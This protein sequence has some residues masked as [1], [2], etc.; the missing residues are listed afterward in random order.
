MVFA[1]VFFVFLL[2]LLGDDFRDGGRGSDS[3]FSWAFEDDTSVS[4]VRIVLESLEG[5]LLDQL[6]LL[7]LML[8]ELLRLLLEERLGLGYSLCLTNRKLSGNGRRHL[9]ITYLRE[10][11]WCGGKLETSLLLIRLLEQLRSLSGEKLLSTAQVEVSH[12]R[13]QMLRLTQIEAAQSGRSQLLR[14]AQIIATRALCCQLLGGAKIVTLQSSRPW[15]ALELVQLLR[16]SQTLGLGKFQ[17]LRLGQLQGTTLTLEGVLGV[18]GQQGGEIHV[19]EIGSEGV[20]LRE[21]GVKSA[22]QGVELFR[23]DADNNDWLLDVGVEWR[24]RRELAQ[25]SLVVQLR[26]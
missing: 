3:G 4:V 9:T 2:L 8:Y 24:P 1:I 12:A 10:S 18:S 6:L 13:R 11:Q 22:G 7:L 20:G 16:E 5:L 15:E 14:S 26:E 21:V 19:V 25:L 17:A 23:T